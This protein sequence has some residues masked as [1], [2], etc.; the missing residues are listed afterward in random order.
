M[1]ICGCANLRVTECEFTAMFADLLVTSVDVLAILFGR[2]S[3][4]GGLEPPMPAFR[5][6]YRIA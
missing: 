6:A 5:A 1:Q 2:L 3:A 4:S